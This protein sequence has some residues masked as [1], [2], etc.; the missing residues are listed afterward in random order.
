[1]ICKASGA[2]MGDVVCSWGHLHSDQDKGSSDRR[3]A[4]W[5]VLPRGTT[6]RVMC[7]HWGRDPGT[8]QLRTHRSDSTHERLR[9]QGLSFNTMID[10]GVGSK[11]KVVGPFAPENFFLGPHLSFGPPF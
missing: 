8:E 10:R 3:R 6:Q 2:G 11:L 9:H 4:W 1:V 7:S 5:A